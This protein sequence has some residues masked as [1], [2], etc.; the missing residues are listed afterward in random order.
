MFKFDVNQNHSKAGPASDTVDRNR[1][2]IHTQW[3]L[4]HL[5]V[6]GIFHLKH[7]PH[8]GTRGKVLCKMSWLYI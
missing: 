6:V 7:Q 8:G 5:I 2:I 4:L 3:T 1:E